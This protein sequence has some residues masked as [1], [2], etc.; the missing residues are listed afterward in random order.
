MKFFRFKVARV[1]NIK[2]TFTD[3]FIIWYNYSSSHR[4]CSIKKVILETSQNS[5]ENTYVR[6]SFLIK[7]QAFV[8]KIENFTELQPPSSLIFFAEILRTFSI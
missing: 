5:Q 4:S 2:S 1:V 3:F 6:V 8:W 7:L